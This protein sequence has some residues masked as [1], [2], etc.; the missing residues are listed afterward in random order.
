MEATEVFPIMPPGPGFDI[1]F[2][3]LLK[4]IC[5]RLQAAWRNFLDVVKLSAAKLKNHW[6]S[7]HI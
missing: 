4:N 7:N 1:F 2:R 6:P 5:F 3:P